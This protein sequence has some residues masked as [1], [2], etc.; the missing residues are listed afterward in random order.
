VLRDQPRPLQAPPALER[1]VWR[2]LTKLP[3]Q[4]FQTMSELKAALE[5][6]SAKPAE[7]QPSIAVLPFSN[8]STDKENEFFSDGLAE[9][10]INALAHIPGLKVTARTSAFAFQGQK[11]DIR[12]IAEALDVRTILEGSVR[13]VGNRIRVT[14]Q[15][16][17]AADGYH[18]WSERYDREMADVFAIQDEI[19]QA[20]AAALQIKLTPAPA[21]HRHYQ[22]NLP[23]Y[24]AYLKARHFQYKSSTQEAWVR[25]RAYYEQAIELDPKFALAHSEFGIYFLVL[26]VI[27][28]LPAREAMPLTRIHAQRAL[29]IDPASPQ[30]HAVLG[31]VAGVY[32][33]DWKGAE[34]RFRLAMAREPVPPMV[35][36]LY[37]TYYLLPIGRTRDA[38]EELERGLK[39]DPLH[40]AGRVNLGQY[41][42][43]V[44]RSED[45]V[46]EYR[47]A[48]EFDENFAPAHALL[49]MDYLSRGMLPEALAAAEKCY[50]LSPW[51]PQAIGQFAGVLVRTG[52]SSRAK[53]VLPKLGAGQAYGAAIG[54]MIF[55]FLGGE[56]DQAIHW[57]EKAIEERNP[58]IFFGLRG[59]IGKVLQS[60]SRW[61]A[62][63][64]MVN[65][66]GAG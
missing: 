26:A 17:S 2:C 51:V 32:D 42:Q 5:Q 12:K 56:I 48:L 47:K 58:G 4:R 64:R 10:I 60:H 1:I 66:P 21:A 45:A 63:M 20:I 16:I 11:Q 6:V 39:E 18:L 53:E 19:A 30:A 43:A 54:L 41:L 61:P 40:L 3:A 44:G 57:L 33:Y 50:S 35:R 9:E 29:E 65:L 13:R 28:M 62:L 34:Q 46:K 14:A 24:E 27:G 37:G 38:A 55:H 23:A 36:F 8:M 15:L 7:E 25:S 49:S 59:P 22:P 52:N 31:V